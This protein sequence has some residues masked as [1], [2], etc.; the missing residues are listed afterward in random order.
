MPMPETTPPPLLVAL[1]PEA[2]SLDLVHAAFWMARERG[3]PWVAVHVECPEA[4]DAEAA[5]QVE[6]WMQEARGLGGG[7]LRIQAPSRAAG[8]LE[9]LRRTGAPLLLVGRQRERWPWGRLGHGL[10]Q[11]LIRRGP[12]AEVRVLDLGEALPEASAWPPPGQRVGAALGLIMALGAVSGLGAILPPEQPLPAL[13]L[14]YLLATAFVAQHW[15][16]AL[17]ALGSALAL[18]CFW[19]GFGRAHATGLGAW[20]LLVLFILVLFGGQFAVR[21]S[22]RMKGQARAMQRREAHMAILLLLGRDLAR[23][24]TPAGVAETLAAQALGAL[25]AR[26]WLLIPE[27]GGWCG[28]PPDPT[29]A[30]PAPEALK[31]LERRRPSLWTPEGHLLLPLLGEQGLEGLLR[32]EPSPRRPLRAADHELLRAFAVQAALALERIESQREAQ[33]ARLQRE[34]ERMR[35]TLLGAV[36]HDLRTPLAAIQGAASSLLL[37]ELPEAQR[38]D[39]LAMIADESERL[40]QML[41]NLL[42]LTRLESETLRIHKEWLP[43]EEVLSAGLQRAERRHGGLAIRT[44]IPEDLPLAPMDGVLMEQLLSNLLGNIRRH[45][46]GS[47]AEIR[48]WAGAESLE[49]EVADRGPGIPEAFR[50]Q[51]FEKFFRLPGAGDGGTGLGLAIAEAIARAHGGRLWVE[52]REGGGARFRLS[53]PLEGAPPEAPE[54]EFP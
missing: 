38:R 5:A 10:A 6:T 53:L 47:P 50:A 49:L 20:P 18:P 7:A 29:L 25:R 42:D 28:L 26:L 27:E 31:E 16:R 17:G 37:Q 14:L 3:C 11:E 54:P 40:A 39:L 32:V 33:R 52:D 43:L 23:A 48:A 21:L 35:N 15:G 36:S 22:E 46:P 41:T 19:F 2:Q 45:A 12:A 24:T 9:A 13:F 44:E 51:V 4:L 34:T 8:L 30:Q 1:G